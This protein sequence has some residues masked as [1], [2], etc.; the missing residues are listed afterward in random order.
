MIR[1]CPGTVD[2]INR[3]LC[4]RDLTNNRIVL[5]N[6]GW[7]PCWTTGNN[8]KER[9]DDYYRQNP[10][11]A[12]TAPVAI[13]L[14]PTTSIKDVPPHM[15]QNLLEVVENLHAAVSADPDN[16]DND[17]AIIQALQ[18]AQQAL[19]QKKK[20]QVHFDGVEMPP[21]RKGKAP[22]SILKHPDQAGAAKEN[23][24]SAA[25]PSAPVPRI[26]VS[27]P[28][29]TTTAARN[30]P[31]AT[32]KNTAAT[33]T[34]CP[35]YQYSTPVE[36]PAVV[37]KV[38]NCALDV[39]VSI[40]QR[41][42]LSI[43]PEAR[44]QDKEL[45]TMRQVSAGTTEVGKLEEVPDDSPAVYSGCAIHDPDDLQV[46]RDSIPLRSIFPLV[47]GKLTVECILDSGCQ[48]VEMNSVIW[49]KLGN[50]LQVER[51]LKMEAANSTITETHGRLR[52]IRFTFDDIDIYLQVQVMPN[53]P[54]DI[55]LGRPFYALTK[56]ITK[57]FMNGDQHLTITD[58]NTRQC[59]TIPTKEWKRH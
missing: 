26:T 38:I 29:I 27:T 19:E 33:N 47:E 12:A 46:G 17:E 37:L 57:D 4:K 28:V 2:Y 45:T 50:N 42:L 36:D 54:Y 44:K 51:T 41:E 55:L 8:I 48:I 1:D 13:P 10:V 23:Q 5:P 18:Q 7:I 35:Q 52:N 34:S 6:N 20:K 56:C 31:T 9:L 43:S 40:T 14:A 16:T 32:V 24:S 22:D 39:P 21:I 25:G 58:P 53:A 15:S 11:P 59:V 49:E 30:I 3:G